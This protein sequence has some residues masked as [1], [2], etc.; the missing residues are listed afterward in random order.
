MKLVT[1]AT[2]DGKTGIGLVTPGDQ[3]V[4][5]TRALEW[6]TPGEGAD[7]AGVPTSMIALLAAGPEWMD[8]VRA[9]ASATTAT[10]GSF[11][12]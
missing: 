5:L 10:E 12:S 8:R 2:D 11:A 4:D 6:A 7:V 1:Y 9:V 3:I